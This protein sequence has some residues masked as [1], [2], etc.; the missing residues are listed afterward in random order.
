[1][2]TAVSDGVEE[3]AGERTPYERGETIQWEAFDGGTCSW[4]TT[5]PR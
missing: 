5:S 2:P 4:S 1:M 3:L